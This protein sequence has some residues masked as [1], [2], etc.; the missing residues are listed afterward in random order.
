M[1]YG[2]FNGFSGLILRRIL[3]IEHLILILLTSKRRGGRR[4]VWRHWISNPGLPAQEASSLSSCCVLP[5]EHSEAADAPY[6]TAVS[7][8]SY[9]PQDQKVL[10]NIA[11]DGG[12]LYHPLVLSLPCK[13][14]LQ[15]FFFV[16]HLMAIFLDFKK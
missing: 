15:T 14:A 7:K 3:L 16:L 8:A 11:P 10:G 2:F 9:Q 13:M 12:F 4:S 6:S 1:C 5:P